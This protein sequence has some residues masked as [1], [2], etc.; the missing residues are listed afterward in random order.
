MSNNNA[1][2]YSVIIEFDRKVGR[3]FK[4]NKRAEF[5]FPTKHGTIIEYHND[6]PQQY[7]VIIGTESFSGGLYKNPRPYYYFEIH[8]NGHNSFFNLVENKETFHVIVDL[9]NKIVYI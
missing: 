5:T 9:R 4:I 1:H 3:Q 8:K 2:N 7:K 6:F